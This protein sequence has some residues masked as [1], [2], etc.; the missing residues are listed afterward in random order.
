MLPQLD[1]RRPRALRVLRHLRAQRQLI[2]RRMPL[3]QRQRRRSLLGLHP[4]LLLQLPLRGLASLPHHLHHVSAFRC[5][6]RQHRER[7]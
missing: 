1:L 3:A 7:P 5:D 4:R 2:Q 6:L